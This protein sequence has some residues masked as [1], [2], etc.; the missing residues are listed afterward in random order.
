[1]PG[2]LRDPVAG[3]EHFAA[4]RLHP[5]DQRRAGLGIDGSGRIVREELERADGVDQSA[6]DEGEPLHRRDA[7]PDAGERSGPGGDGIAIDVTRRQAVAGQQRRQFARQA[8]GVRPRRIAGPFLDHAVP[9]QR[10]AAGRGGRIEGQDQ[11]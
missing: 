10:H 7:D 6:A 1:V 5:H 4:I 2:R 3:R 9:P 11:H 8:L